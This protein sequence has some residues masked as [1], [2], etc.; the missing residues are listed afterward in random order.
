MLQALRLLGKAHT[1]FPNPATKKQNT[2]VT[3][4]RSD[5]VNTMKPTQGQFFHES[6]RV[7]KQAF[8]SWRSNNDA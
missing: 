8:I 5:T 2:L 1:G 3:N 6:R 4:S 7:K